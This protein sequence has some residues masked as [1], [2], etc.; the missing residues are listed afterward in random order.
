M[1]QSGPSTNSKRKPRIGIIGTGKMAFALGKAF[2]GAGH[3]VA[4]G[5]RKPETKN[6]FHEMVGDESKIY[7]LQAAIDAGQIIIITI[8][9]S[10]VAETVRRFANSLEGK[11]V[12]DITNPFTSQPND[13]SSGAQ[14]TAKIIGEKAR[15]VAAF[16][17][18]FAETI[19]EPKDSSGQPR[20]VHYAG[21][22]QDA[23]DIVAGLIKEIGFSPV[24][25]GTLAQSVALDHMVPLMIRLDESHHG[26]SRKSSWRIASP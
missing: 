5:S 22:D 20:E 9:Y 21:D 24:D 23:K 15:V 3:F 12:I 11:V 7:G 2:L 17:T 1:H 4:F 6:E 18:N 10:Q 14:I 26:T 25:C 16:K 13:G 19:S 8:P